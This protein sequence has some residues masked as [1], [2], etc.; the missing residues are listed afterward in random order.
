M[1]NYIWI[2]KNYYKL[3]FFETK[4]KKQPVREFIL[5]LTQD[6]RKTIGADIFVVQKTFPLGLPLVCK[7]GSHLWEIRSTISQG[8]VRIFFTI[9]NDFLI[10]LHGFLKKTQKTPDKELAVA[11]ARLKEFEEMNQ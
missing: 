1:Y 5:S 11:L 3:C 4:N 7:M 2:E 6:D 10:L 9:E 8:I